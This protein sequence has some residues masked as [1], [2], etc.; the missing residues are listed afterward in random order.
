MSFIDDVR[1]RPGLYFGGTTAGGPFHLHEFLFTALLEAGGLRSLTVR[2]EGARVIVEGDSILNG[3][4]ALVALQGDEKLLGDLWGLATVAAVSSEF[5]LDVLSSEAWWSWR[6]AQGVQRDVSSLRRREGPGTTIAFVPDETI[7]QRGNTIPM[8]HVQRRL[9]EL[10]ML[11]AGLL[12]QAQDSEGG[13]FALRW[14]RGLT[15]FLEVERVDVVEDVS[16]TWEGVHI[17]AAFGGQRYSAGWMGVIAVEVRGTGWPSEGRLARCW[18]SLGCAKASG[19]RCSRPFAS[20]RS[21]LH[22]GIEHCTL[23]T[24]GHHG[25]RVSMASLLEALQPPATSRVTEPAHL[26]DERAV[27]RSEADVLQRPSTKA[28]PKGVMV[29]Q[30]IPNSGAVHRRH[31]AAAATAKQPSRQRAAFVDESIAWQHQPINQP[32]EHRRQP[33]P[34]RREEP[35]HVLSPFECRSHARQVGLVGHGRLVR[36]A[37]DGVELQRGHVDEF[38]PCACTFGASCVGLRESDGERTR[39][40]MG[41]QQRQVG[42]APMMQRVRPSG[43]CDKCM[44]AMHQCMP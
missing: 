12:V 31:V 5:E 16:A 43:T 35:R 9:Q 18:S 3:E 17:S 36:A 21:P 13:Q 28:A 27:D 7:F 33:R 32:L 19:R 30:P 6:G 39:T 25:Q 23:R 24:S 37:E 40:G 41:G 34:P 11:N 38:D 20:R 29:G 4:A 44:G 26:V 22:W 2:R 10:A 15:D 1:K 14:P 42:H 8:A